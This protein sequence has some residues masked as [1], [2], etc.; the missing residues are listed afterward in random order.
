MPMQSQR[1]A[2]RMAEHPY[3]DRWMDDRREPGEAP[4]RH[5]DERSR[6]RSDNDPLAELARLIG[7]DDPFGPRPYDHRSHSGEHERHAEAQ[8]A[9]EWL[10][11]PPQSRSF[12]RNDREQEAAFAAATCNDETAQTDD[13][14]GRDWQD[15]QTYRAEY[16]PHYDDRPFEAQ[17]LKA[18]HG[19][20]GA[21]FYAG[22]PNDPGLYLEDENFDPRPLRRRRGGLL[23][24]VAVA[25]L[26][27]VGTAAAFGYRA[28]IGSPATAKPPVIL[29]DSGPNKVIP[30][31]PGGEGSPNKVIYD[32][33]PERSPQGERVVVREE[34]PVD[35]PAAPQ[36]TLPAAPSA[37]PQSSLPNQ[38]TP[39]NSAGAEPKRVRTVTI[40]PDQPVSPD[41]VPVRATAQP[42]SAPGHSANVRGARPASQPL[43]I[44]PQAAEPTRTAAIAPATRAAIPEGGYMVQLTSQKSESEAQSSYRALQAKYPAVLGDRQPV[45]RRADLGEKKGVYYRA[46]I[47]PFATAEKANEFCSSLK[48]AGGQCIVQRN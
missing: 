38:P 27:I 26:A 37:M 48:S 34:Q 10:T 41:M 2:G 15:D 23:T 46:Q 30:A 6:V 14:H 9:P 21:P 28:Y 43:A 1:M 13:R 22:D 12:D 16:E 45:I 5:G 33:L 40:R 24:V 47:G 35:R 42:Q 44:A 8:D 32:R 11:R 17:E 29:A 7:Q 39:S 18:E 36:P 25:G 3:R 20:D 31:Q 19:H 4:D